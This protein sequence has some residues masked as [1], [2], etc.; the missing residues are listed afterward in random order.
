M[1]Y[2][3]KGKR[4]PKLSFDFNLK[5]K[6]NQIFFSTLVF[7]SKLII[8]NDRKLSPTL[9]KIQANK[10]HILIKNYPKENKSNEDFD[11]ND[12]KST[13]NLTSTLISNEQNIL[14]QNF[15]NHI[16]TENNFDIN[17]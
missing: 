6:K 7:R 4:S 17:N 8:K 14:K 15:T 13:S 9:K 10:N 16:I 12:D 2:L 3:M 5:P 1:N 11:I